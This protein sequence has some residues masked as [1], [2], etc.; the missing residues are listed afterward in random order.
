MI[1]LFCEI[2]FELFFYSKSRRIEKLFFL[3]RSS[4]ASNGIA[5]DCVSNSI[6]SFRPMWVSKS[7]SWDYEYHSLPT[8][9]AGAYVFNEETVF[10]N[11][12]LF[13]AIFV[14]LFFLFFKI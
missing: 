8:E 2:F 14:E 1:I 9:L 12:H 13:F 3:L 5:K 10:V 7:R 6:K 4:S 11:D